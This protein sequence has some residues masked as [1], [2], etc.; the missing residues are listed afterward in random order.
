MNTSPWE[1]L[2][3]TLLLANKTKTS[4]DLPFP[5]SLVPVGTDSLHRPHLNTFLKVSWVSDPQ[6]LSTLVSRT[7]LVHPTV[8]EPQSPLLSPLADCELSTQVDLTSTRKTKVHHDHIFRA[9]NLDMQSGGTSVYSIFP[10]MRQFGR[11]SLDATMS[12]FC[13]YFEAFWK[14]KLHQGW[15]NAS[16]IQGCNTTSQ[17]LHP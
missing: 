6:H 14:I 16:R 10:H 12:I 9:T 17:Y 3:W 1:N 4:W 13:R 11:S 7:G 8:T 2:G 5:S 15:S